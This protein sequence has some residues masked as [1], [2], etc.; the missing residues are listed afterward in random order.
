[1]RRTD[2]GEA[3]QES[4]TTTHTRCLRCAGNTVDQHAAIVQRSAMGLWMPRRWKRVNA[5]VVFKDG[6]SAILNAPQHDPYQVAIPPTRC[7]ISHEVHT[8]V[9]T[10]V[11]E[12]SDEGGFTVV[13]PALPGC[14]SEGETRE[15]ALENI[16]QAIE[17]YLQ[18]V[19]DDLPVTPDAELLQ[20]SP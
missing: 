12:A 20:I 13:V 19:E 18:P 10:V 5:R 17:L 9:L 3:F 16:R 1:M 11:L 4:E 14:I 7:Y 8:M 15:E 2:R 6:V